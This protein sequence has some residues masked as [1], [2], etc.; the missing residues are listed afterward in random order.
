[1][2]AHSEL[3]VQKFIHDQGI[4]LMALQ[5]TGCWEPT[6]GFFKDKR[7]M[8]NDTTNGNNL[9]GVALIVDKDLLPEAIAIESTETDAVWCQIKLGNKRVLVGSVYI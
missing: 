1:M 8:R 3:S 9:R 6:D 7:I 2:S 4:K 5:E